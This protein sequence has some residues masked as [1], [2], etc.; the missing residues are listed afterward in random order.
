MQKTST[1]LPQLCVIYKSVSGKI[2]LP[3]IWPSRSPG[4]QVSDSLAWHKKL[5]L[6]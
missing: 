5:A 4:R 1:G 2:L 3:S 6:H